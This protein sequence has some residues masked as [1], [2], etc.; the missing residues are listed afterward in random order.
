MVLARLDGSSVTA[1]AEKFAT[2]AKRVSTWTKRFE[3]DGLTG[4]DEKPGRGRRRSIPETK[5]ARVI[6]EATRAARTRTRW[7]LRMLSRH[8]G[9]AGPTITP[10][11][12]D[13]RKAERWLNDRQVSV[14]GVVTKRLELP[15]R[16]G[17]RAIRIDAP[18]FQT[19]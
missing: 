14:D 9:E 8:A 7:S 16:P 12:R 6:T 3:T 17:E 15:Y 19:Q 1:V 10:F 5:V 11:T 18:N 4:L 13:M 2:T